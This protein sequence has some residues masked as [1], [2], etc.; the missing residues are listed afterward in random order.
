[1]ERGSKVRVLLVDEQFYGSTDFMRD[2]LP[3]TP[4]LKWSVRRAMVTRP[5]RT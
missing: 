3:P 1:M 2:I 4:T 5:L